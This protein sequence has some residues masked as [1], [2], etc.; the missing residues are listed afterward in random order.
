LTVLARKSRELTVEV[1]DRE[2]RSIGEHLA[3]VEA[4]VDADPGRAAQGMREHLANAHAI[5]LE[6][7]ERLFSLSG[8]SVTKPGDEENR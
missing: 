3:I 1:P 5:P 8:R 7:R 4:I 2:E 6:Y